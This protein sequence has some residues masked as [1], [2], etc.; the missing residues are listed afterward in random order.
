MH[1]STVLIS[2]FVT[3]LVSPA[4]SQARPEPGARVRV[5]TDATRFVGTLNRYGANEI[6]IASRD[7]ERV[8]P[9]STVARFEMRR[10]SQAGRG[11]LYGLV[12]GVV[13]GGVAGVLFGQEHNFDID[14]TEGD[15]FTFGLLGA[16]LLGAVGA[17]VG[18]LIGSTH[19]R[20]EETSIRQLSMQLE[21]PPS[22][23]FTVA[24]S[25]AL[26]TPRVP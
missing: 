2:L 11:A 10:G 4:T 20:W 3:S 24:L 13:A 6:V 7:G 9:L 8:V 14:A 25:I 12:G 22:G 26:R 5:T 18:A 16:G 19:D 1:R 23:G 21:V 17:G 15:P